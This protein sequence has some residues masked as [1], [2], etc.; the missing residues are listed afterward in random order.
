MS[1]CKDLERPCCSL[2]SNTTHY[3][4]AIDLL[5]VVSQQQAHQQFGTMGSLAELDES[6]RSQLK[7]LFAADSLASGSLLVARELFARYDIDNSE[8]I[9]FNELKQLTTN[10]CYQYKLGKVN[11][12]FQASIEQNIAQDIHW[13]LDEFVA[14]FLTSY[15]AIHGS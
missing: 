9:E 3:W 12:H 14:W 10:V 13:K 4:L 6:T 8:T 2:W 5:L 11:R 15:K 1:T 7:S